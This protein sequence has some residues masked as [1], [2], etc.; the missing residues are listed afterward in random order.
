MPVQHF[1]DRVK[2]ITSHMEKHSG[3]YFVMLDEVF[4]AKV[5]KIPDAKKVAM[6]IA[7]AVAQFPDSVDVGRAKDDDGN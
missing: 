1:T 2:I 5:Y 3:A 6:M 4:V 7:G